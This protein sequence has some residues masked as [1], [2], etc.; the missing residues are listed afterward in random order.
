MLIHNSDLPLTYNKE[1]LLNPWF[2]LDQETL[3]NNDQ[4]DL[5]G[6]SLAAADFDGDGRDELVVGAPEETTSINNSSG[7]VFL[8]H[9]SGQRM[10]G[11]LGIH[12][13]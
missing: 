5:F 2:V 9:S 10:A 7:Y 12:Q 13:E 6:W 8:F 1:N 11:W 4:N 3:G